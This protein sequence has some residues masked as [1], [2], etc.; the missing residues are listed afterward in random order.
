MAWMVSFPGDS[1]SWGFFFLFGD[2]GGAAGR[3][4]MIFY[5]SGP[6]GNTQLYVRTSLA[7]VDTRWRIYSGSYQLFPVVENWMLKFSGFAVYLP[8]CWR[9]DICMFVKMCVRLLVRGIHCCV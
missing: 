2:F 4:M 3:G 1:G 8:C 7:I 9:P 6:F 5:S